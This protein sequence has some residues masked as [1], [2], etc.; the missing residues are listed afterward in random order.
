[1]PQVPHQ[2]ARVAATW[3]RVLAALTAAGVVG[4]IGFVVVRNEPF[5]D[6]NIVVLI[7]TLLSLAI[8]V[9]GATIPGFLNVSWRGR[10]LAIRAGGALALFVVSY[11][12]APSVVPSLSNEAIPPLKNPRKISMRQSKWIPPVASVFAAEPA[13]RLRAVYEG[14]GKPWRKPYDVILSNAGSEQR[15]LTSFKVRWLYRM[16]IQSAIDHGEAVKPI[17]KY[18]ILLPINTDEAHRLF[19][20]S[21]DMYPPIV[22]PPQNASGPSVVSIRL[23]VLYAFQGRL[24]YHPNHDW[25]IFYE[26]WVQDDSHEELRILSRSWRGGDAPDWVDRFRAETGHRK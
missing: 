14:D 26:V 20:K 19:E 25:N 15:I 6:A 23:E 12:L 10:G 16:G 3:E 24:N 11:L 5:A 17:E 13:L 4:L 1:M 22:L 8:A 18:S 21:S 2:P 9:L 7:R